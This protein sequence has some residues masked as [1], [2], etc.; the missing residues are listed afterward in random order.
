M[1][2]AVKNA[3]IAV[4]LL[5][6]V[7]GFFFPRLPVDELIAMRYAIFLWSLLAILF[8]YLVARQFLLDKWYSLLAVAILIALPDFFTADWQFKEQK[9]K[10]IRRIRIVQITNNY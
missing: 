7:Y 6:F 4:L 10:Y 2:G 8:T 3:I 9:R 5:F 1:K